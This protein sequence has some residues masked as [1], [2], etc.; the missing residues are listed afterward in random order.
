[1]KRRVIVFVALALVLAPVFIRL[2]FWQLR[3]LEERR[4]RNRALAARLA[5]PEVAFEQLRDTT[6]F[7]RATVAGT[8]DYEHEIILTGR[9][10][11]GS[12]GVYI[13]TPLRRAGRDSAVVV[14][15]GWVYAPDAASAELARWRERRSAFRGYV[16]TLPATPPATP[17][18]GGGRK[19]RTLTAQ[20]VRQLLPYPAAPQYVVSQDSASSDSVPA[21][22]PLPVLDDGPHL[23]YAIQWFS[24]AII[25]IV[26]A[27]A[28]VLRAGRQGTDGST[29]A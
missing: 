20:G 19:L 7:R 6:S 21:R 25:A 11:N 3:R 24:F 29:A 14:I 15:R 17:P 10:R 8:P 16:A 22:I 12:P 5:E 18:S 28:V 9:S 13:L 27:G 2:G 26:G 1:M 23:S 4:A